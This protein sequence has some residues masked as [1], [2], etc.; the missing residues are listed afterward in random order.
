[1]RLGLVQMLES[2]GLR[3]LAVQATTA[4]VLLAVLEG[5]PR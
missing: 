2:S 1:M 5:A 4:D 3:R